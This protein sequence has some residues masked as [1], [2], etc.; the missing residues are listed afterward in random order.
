MSRAIDGRRENKKDVRSIDGSRANQKTDRRAKY[1]H[2]T[3]CS[4]KAFAA[5]L[6]VGLVTSIDITWAN[7]VA[8]GIKNFGS[9]VHSGQFKSAKLDMFFL[10]VANGASVKLLPLPSLDRSRQYAPK[11]DIGQYVSDTVANNLFE[12]TLNS[13]L[14]LHPM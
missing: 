11:N 2:A 4:G 8:E 5:R 9:T 7:A 3:D 13:A 6:R 14:L 12:Q 1:S 10:V